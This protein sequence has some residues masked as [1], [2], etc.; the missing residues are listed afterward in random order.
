V[1]RFAVAG[2]AL[3]LAACGQTPPRTPDSGS[4]SGDG[5]RITGN[6]RIGWQQMATTASEL[7]G[8]G[9]AAYVDDV[10]WELSDA[11]C[12]ASPDAN[13][14]SCSA[15]LPQMSAGRHTI[16]LVAYVEAGRTL[17]S[18]RSTPLVVVVVGASTAPGSD[19]TAATTF[20]TADGVPLRAE[21]IARELEDVTDVAHV[22]DGRMFVAER[23][24]RIRTLR[25]NRLLEP[26]IDIEDVLSDQGGLLAIAPAP[27]YPQTGH[28]YVAY[29]VG[30]TRTAGTGDRTLRVARFRAVGDTLGERA[31]VTEIGPLSPE[32]TAAMRFG[33][34]DKL[35]V[36]VDDGGDP[37]R[38]G[39]LGSFNGKVLRINADGTTPRDQ[40]GGSPIFAD[41][42]FAPR[43]L[44]WSTWDPQATLWLVDGGRGD[45]ADTLQA[46]AA[47]AGRLRRGRTIIRYAFPRDAGAKDL[48]VY[49]SD[50]I[51]SLRGDLL[52]ASE[53]GQALLRLRF[54][55][56]DR[57]RLVG[58][59]RLLQDAFG[60]VTAVS[61]APDGSIVVASERG[62][63]R[64]SP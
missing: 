8:F 59:E 36:A 48:A 20:T 23:A 17:E 42:V 61:V 22:P 29:V 44:D 6:E 1:S 11:S 62:L 45:S 52:V 24:G 38:A 25:D 31:I 26:A 12:A 33:P 37:N 55:P 18:A 3:A 57:R 21:I 43:A 4:S 9:Y 47:D 51:A 35:Y 2:L 28:L 5:D 32:P 50:L 14:F 46:V 13:G 39:D 41:Q 64:I 54:D 16:E 30:D 34:D 40:E 49:R 15:R 58:S 56:A 60:P 27:D 63:V 10:R 53:D 19:R 7:A